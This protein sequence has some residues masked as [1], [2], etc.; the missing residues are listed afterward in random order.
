TTRCC[1]SSWP[2]ASPRA[3]ALHH[4]RRPPRRAPG[5][6]AEDLPQ[7]MRVV[8]G[9]RLGSASTTLDGDERRHATR[10]AFAVLIASGVVVTAGVLVVGLAIGGAIGRGLLVFAP[11]LLASILQDFWRAILFRD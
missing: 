6:P 3:R 8:R 9:L 10:S 1:S 11:W 7:P 4:R 5:P 2:S